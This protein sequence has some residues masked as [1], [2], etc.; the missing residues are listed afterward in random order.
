[1]GWRVACCWRWRSLALGPVAAQTSKEAER[2]LQKLRTRAEGRGAGTPRAGG[3][4]AARHRASCASAD[5]KVARTGRVLAQ[6]ETAL[7]RETRAMEELQRKRSDLQAGMQKQ[8]EE[9]ASLLRSAY[10][11]GNNAPLKLLLSQDRVA[12]ANRSAGLPPLPAARARAPHPAL[13]HDLAEL[14]AVEAQIVERRQALEGTRQQ[15]KQ[16]VRPWPTTARTR[17]A[18][19]A[20]LDERY[21]D[22]SAREQA[23]GQDAKA[24]ESLLANLRAAAARA[25]AER[26]AAAAA[27]PRRRPPPRKPRK[28][29]P[30]TAPPP[31]RPGKTPPAV[32]SAPP[33]KVGGL[34]WPLSGNL[35]ARYGGTLP[36]GRTSS[37]VL[38][39]ARG[40]QHGHRGGRR[41]RGVLRMDD[42]L[43]P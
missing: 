40:R 17:A 39:G 8:R 26:R 10:R 3:R 30:P 15:Q 9:L 7:Q 43:R 24:L 12:D 36:D 4:S 11:I 6:T 16:Q 28:P 41:H 5:E 18:T 1:M 19:V 2:K 13:T 34:G 37:G 14:Q 35:L 31:P 27:R 38:I 25:E 20:S 32:A 23:L 21:K 22:R 42:R 29:R 33:P